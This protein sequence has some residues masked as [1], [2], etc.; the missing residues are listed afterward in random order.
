M[1]KDECEKLCESIYCAC[2]KDPSLS[3]KLPSEA[4]WIVANHLMRYAVDLLALGGIDEKGKDA[5]RKYH[6]EVYVWWDKYYPKAVKKEAKR[7]SKLKRAQRKRRKPN[8]EQ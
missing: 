3:R 1:K 2:R 5:L 7:S 4:I 6:D 8:G